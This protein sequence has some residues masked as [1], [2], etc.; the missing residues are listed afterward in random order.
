LGL[1]VFYFWTNR[2]K[3]KQIETQLEENKANLTRL[4]NL[5]PSPNATNIARAKQEVQTARAAV[6]QAKTFFSPIPFQP[7]TGQAFKS[8]LDQTSSTSIEKPRPRALLCRAGL[9]VHLC[10]QKTQL[11]FPAEA[12]PALPNNSPKFAKSVK[13]SS[14]AK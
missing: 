12:F 5:A 9:C 1:G 4:V 10:P 6:E 7:V 8:L 2:Q 13:S 11:Q 14:D 3:N